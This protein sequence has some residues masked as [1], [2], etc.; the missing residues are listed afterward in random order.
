MIAFSFIY[1]ITPLSYSHLNFL[2]FFNSSSNLFKLHR[3]MF[4]IYSAIR[5]F[6]MII[7]IYFYLFVC[8][9]YLLLL[10]MIIMLLLYLIMINIFIIHFHFNIVVMMLLLLYCFLNCI[11]IIKIDK[12]IYYIFLWRFSSHIYYYHFYELIY[13]KYDKFLFIDH[14]IL[15]SGSTSSNL[16]N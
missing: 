3:Y 13:F 14:E 12:F 6:A 4:A 2:L 15:H 1:L 16:F 8:I 10:N 9:E 11:L 7:I 5:P